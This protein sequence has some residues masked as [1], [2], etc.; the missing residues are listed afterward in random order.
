MAHKMSS[1]C[2][3]QKPK[4]VHFKAKIYNFLTLVFSANP[5]MY[6]NSNFVIILHK[7]IWKKISEQDNLAKLQKFSVLPWW[8]NL[9]K[10]KKVQDSFEFL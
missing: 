2:F 3:S 1:M 8:P 6:R 4:K 5:K 9:P 7:K 10:N